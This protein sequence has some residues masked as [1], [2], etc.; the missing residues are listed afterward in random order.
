MTSIREYQFGDYFC[1]IRVID[2]VCEEGKWMHTAHFEPTEQ[3]IQ[4]LTESNCGHK[5]LVAINDDSI[6]GWCRIFI[7]GQA[8]DL[9]IGILK[10]YRNHGV[11]TRL[12]QVAMNW[13]REHDLVVTLS[14]RTEN[15]RALHLFEKIG[16]VK[17]D[18]KSQMLAMV[19]TGESIY[20]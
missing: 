16:F 6:I 18:F 7:R 11:G 15:L 4:V 12:L 1:L 10:A 3:W 14:C 19:Y 8:G 17:S 5:L 2:S 9:G 13:A 20:A